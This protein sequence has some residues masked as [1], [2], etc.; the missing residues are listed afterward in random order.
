M[1]SY[2]TRTQDTPIKSGKEGWVNCLGN[3][4]TRVALPAH[5]MH[6]MEGGRRKSFEVGESD[7]YE[8]E[9]IPLYNDLT[10]DDTGQVDL[11]ICLSHVNEQSG[12]T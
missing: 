12:Y 6:K 4:F 3:V 10:L 1:L 5:Q 8:K 9:R 2:G 11:G 7:G